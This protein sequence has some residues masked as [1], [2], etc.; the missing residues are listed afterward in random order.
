MG[1]DHVA[2]GE[3]HQGSRRRAGAAELHH[4]VAADV[5]ALETK[6]VARGAIERQLQ[7]GV[8]VVFEQRAERVEARVIGSRFAVCAVQPGLRVQRGPRD[9]LEVQLEARLRRA[10][11][12][13][14]QVGGPVHPVQRGGERCGLGA[15][16]P[17]AHALRTG[18]LRHTQR[19]HDPIAV[20]RR[21]FFEQ[22]V[23]GRPGTGCRFGAAV[24]DYLQQA[25][26]VLGGQQ[27]IQR[28]R[29]AVRWRG[30]GIGPVATWCSGPPDQ[31]AGRR[32][33]DHGHGGH[34]TGQQRRPA[35]LRLGDAGGRCNVGD[36]FQWQRGRRQGL[37]GHRHRLVI[38]LCLRLAPR[39]QRRAGRAGRQPGNGERGRQRQRR[40][41]PVAPI[42]HGQWRRAI[43]NGGR[44]RNAARMQLAGDVAGESPLDVPAEGNV[45][46]HG[47]LVDGSAPVSA[48]VRRSMHGSCA[49]SHRTGCGLPTPPGWCSCRA[50]GT[51]GWTSPFPPANTP[52]RARP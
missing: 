22:G 36:V 34:G 16:W 29:K 46:R 44:R 7:Q 50:C 1:A 41:Q 4:Q 49:V 3:Q 52:V 42:A 38:A 15:A 6:D 2:V 17:T 25:V 39:Q 24:G 28:L 40:H 47:N 26:L 8:A 13:G 32:A 37:A 48:Q 30:S 45:E 12:S 31:Q 43:G 21:Q 35:R 14:Q 23:G 19:G 11:R 27:V 5:G 51:A 33:A 10:H 18:P 9:L 20:G